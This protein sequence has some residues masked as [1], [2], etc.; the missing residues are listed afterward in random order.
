[1]LNLENFE[2]LMKEIYK[3][4]IP[5]KDD[6]IAQ[7][8]RNQL[9]QEL[10]EALCRDFNGTRTVDGIILEIGNEI[11]GAVFV[12]LNLKIKGF[13]YDVEEAA[14]IY[15]EKVDRKIEKA[16]K[17]EKQ[18]S[19]LV[20]M[21]D[22]VAIPIVTE[23]TMEVKTMTKLVDFMNEHPLALFGAGLATTIAVGLALIIFMAQCYWD[24]AKLFLWFSRGVLWVEC[25][26]CLLFAFGCWG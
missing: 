7:T 13:D 17:K 22:C 21:R 16:K 10:M 4:E 19:G 9:R 23:T 12:E 3:R 15:Q 18:K 2:S 11:E 25:C 26:W 1:M 24:N 14:Q 20:T 8:Y 6:K 5:V